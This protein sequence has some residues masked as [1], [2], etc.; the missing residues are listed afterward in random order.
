M[1]CAGWPEHC[2]P[3]YQLEDIAYDGNAEQVPNQATPVWSLNP[4]I[5]IFPDA[6]PSYDQAGIAAEQSYASEQYR[7]ND[8]SQE[9][10]TSA[11]V[12]GLGIVLPLPTNL[13]T[14]RR[15]TFGT[16]GSAYGN[17]GRVVSDAAST[18]AFQPSLPTGLKVPGDRV[19]DT[20][21]FEVDGRDSQ[22]PDTAVHQSQ[23]PSGESP[24]TQT[25]HQK[26]CVLCCS[27]RIPLI[28]FADY[29]LQSGAKLK[30]YNPARYQSELAHQ[31]DRRRAYGAFLV[32]QPF[33]LRT[34]DL[35]TIKSNQRLEKYRTQ[36]NMQSLWQRTGS[37]MVCPSS[38][39]SL[40][41]QG[42]F[43]DHRTSLAARQIA[44][45]REVKRDKQRKPAARDGSNAMSVFLLSNPSDLCRN[46]VL[47]HY[48]RLVAKNK[49]GQSA[50]PEDE[51]VPAERTERQTSGT[52]QQ[53]TSGAEPYT[54]PSQSPNPMHPR[55]QNRDGTASSQPT[56][57]TLSTRL[58]EQGPNWNLY[59]QP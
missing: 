6:L 43:A 40:A 3:A 24:D 36:R 48:S 2:V 39:I 56:A 59:G 11:A 26:K 45:G 58:V 25:Y 21:S 35:L 23:T 17:Q 52:S 53:R 49:S 15:I 34:K 29:L 8:G 37:H 1:F 7:P 54:E 16:G 14:P 47:I 51:Q 44:K 46:Y 12:S 5:G 27:I 19:L 28:S 31:R 57:D 42:W 30:K 10:Y 9:P 32:N 4:L 33:D 18:L 38:A 50:A 22:H 20:Q 41:A 55:D 13:G